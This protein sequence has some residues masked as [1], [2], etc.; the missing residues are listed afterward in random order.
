MADAVAEWDPSAVDAVAEA[1]SEVAAVREKLRGEV[2]AAVVRPEADAATVL[3]IDTIACLLERIAA[4]SAAC[5]R[6][7]SRV[8]ASSQGSLVARA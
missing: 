5:T 1:Q 7:L 6:R 4:V 3:R 8:G 2:A